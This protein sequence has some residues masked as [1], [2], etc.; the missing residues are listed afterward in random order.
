MLDI[1]FNHLL[2][3]SVTDCPGEISVFPQLPRPKS[4]F[5]SGELAEQSP[6][7]VALDDSD[8][9]SNR[10]G[11]RERD[12]NVYVFLAHFQF[13]NFKPIVLTYFLDQ[14]FRSFLNLH[15]LKYI[16]PIFR[17]PYQMVTRIIDRMT[18]PLEP[19]ALYISQCRARA[20][21][22][23]GDFPVPLITPSARHAFLPAASRGVSC[24]GVP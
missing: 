4:L 8:H 3:H 12:Q 11:R 7:T 17:T 13:D 20:Y 22:D 14:L 6:P 5:Q 9:F 18:R 19:H 16:F 1:P 15:P 21:A 10:L 2:S 23:K 24:K